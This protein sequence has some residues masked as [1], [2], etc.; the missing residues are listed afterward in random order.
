MLD[1]G[2]GCMAVSGK[3]SGMVG[4]MV[5]EVEGRRVSVLHSCFSDEEDEN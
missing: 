4:E 2:V 5:G 3:V 1:G